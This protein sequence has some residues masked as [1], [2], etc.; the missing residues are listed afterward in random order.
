MVTVSLARVL[1]WSQHVAKSQVFP[2]DIGD[3]KVEAAIFDLY[4]KGEKPCATVSNHCV[5]AV[6][7]D[8]GLLP[9]QQKITVKIMVGI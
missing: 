5:G 4:L 1:E 9:W 7:T 2:K 8:K 6:M 3:F